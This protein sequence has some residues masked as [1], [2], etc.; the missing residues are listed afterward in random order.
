MAVDTD[1]IKNNIHEYLD[2]H[3]AKELLR[4]VTIEFG[5]RW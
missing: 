2:Q 3:E 5:R 4:F 1:L